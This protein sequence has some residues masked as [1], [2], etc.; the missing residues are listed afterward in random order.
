MF[1][2]VLTA[3]EQEGRGLRAYQTVASRALSILQNDPDRAAPLFLI[4]QAAED[5]VEA[6]ERMPMTTATVDAMCAQMEGIVIDLNE[7]WSGDDPALKLDALTRTAKRITEIR[8][9]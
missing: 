7:A 6:H 4:A 5:F 3:L 2:F 1:N 8:V 9:G